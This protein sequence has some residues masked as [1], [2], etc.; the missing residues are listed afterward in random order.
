MRL[1]R[2]GPGGRAMFVMSCLALV[3]IAS[4]GRYTL[5]PFG[6][7]GGADGPCNCIRYDGAVE[8]VVRSGG[9]GPGW[10]GPV[11]TAGALAV[12]AIGGVRW[13]WRH[14]S[15]PERAAAP[16]ENNRQPAD[17]GTRAPDSTF[18]EHTAAPVE[19]A[20]RRVERAVQRHDVV[21]TPARTAGATGRIAVTLGAPAGSVDELVDV[22]DRAR[23]SPRPTGSR[24]ET[25]AE[26]LADEVIDA[27]SGRRST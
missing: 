18:D 25:D 5:V 16:T 23:Y 27:L 10:V 9:S 21:L 19:R 15:R 17:T 4:T 11:V 26:R 6:E 8:Q 24:D 14:R 2:W 20:W 22:Y 7:V 1:V 12:L 13:L 3:T